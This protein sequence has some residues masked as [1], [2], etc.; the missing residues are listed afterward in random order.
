MT[1]IRARR[2]DNRAKTSAHG[3]IT[4]QHRRPNCGSRFA[5]SI[6]VRC[7]AVHRACWTKHGH[8]RGLTH[9]QDHRHHSLKPKS[10]PPVLHRREDP[11]HLVGG[12][13][14]SNGQPEMA[15]SLL[16][17]C[18]KLVADDVTGYMC[19]AQYLFNCWMPWDG[20]C[21]RRLGG[22]QVESTLGIKRSENL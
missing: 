14:D 10:M 3:R 1:V 22:D 15:T 21:R 8:Y 7:F 19:C 11:V 5:G 18:P 6:K 12:T 13:A 4:H 17:W 20:I 16:L 2:S 9:E